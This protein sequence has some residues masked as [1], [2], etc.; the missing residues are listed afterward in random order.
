VGKSWRRILILGIAFALAIG[1]TFFFAYRAGRQARHFHS[2]NEPIRPWMSIP[3][4][5]HTRHVPA[6]V[7]F[8]AIGV[9]PDPK[10][11][12]SVRHLAHDL[13]R[14]VPDLLG[15]LQATVDATAHSSGSQPQ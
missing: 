10:D 15:K 13:H 11:R 5:A 14:T 6:P 9:Q 1:G 2:A 12:R 8:Q 3:F 7:L 4:I